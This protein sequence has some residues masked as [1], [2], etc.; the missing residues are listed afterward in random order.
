MMGA[1]GRGIRGRGLRAG[2]LLMATALLLSACSSRK[3]VV[4]LPPDEPG[5]KP[6]LMTSS[7][8]LGSL[9]HLE[10]RDGRQIHGVVTA[11]GNEYI[12]LRKPYEGR[13]HGS[14]E[15]DRFLW[16]DIV[17]MDVQRSENTQFILGSGVGFVTAVILSTAALLYLLSGVSFPSS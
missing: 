15:S 5:G 9:V 16:T 3:G 2:A 13:R 4:L 12:E 7:L 14:M 11:L 6:D 8:T 17:E 1:T 10:L